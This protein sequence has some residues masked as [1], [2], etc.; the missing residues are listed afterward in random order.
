MRFPL[1]SLRR[2]WTL[3]LI[4]KVYLAFNLVILLNGEFLTDVKWYSLFTG[5]LIVICFAIKL[6]LT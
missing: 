6:R 5:I 4:G 1:L 3:H 2:Y